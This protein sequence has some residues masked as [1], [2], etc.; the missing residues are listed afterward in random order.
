MHT[1]GLTPSC[2]GTF[3]YQWPNPTRIAMSAKA[4]RNQLSHKHYAVTVL[5]LR[6]F[7]LG[8]SRA[9]MPELPSSPK[10]K[11]AEW[12]L[13]VLP[14]PAYDGCPALLG[15]A[16]PTEGPEHLSMAAW[17]AREVLQ[18]GA[19]TASLNEWGEQSQANVRLHFPGYGTVKLQPKRRARR[20]EE[21][22][23]QHTWPDQSTL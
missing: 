1:L 5:T 16:V 11:G 17:A 12:S 9:R 6:V 10:Y 19:R 2:P 22:V 7:K 20:E 21:D 3:D 4:G 18:G 13:A 8:L 15:I 14:L 23:L